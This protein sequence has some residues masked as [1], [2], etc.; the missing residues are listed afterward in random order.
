[1]PRMTAEQITTFLADVGFHPALEFARIETIAER[2]IT[3]RM[4]FRTDFIR[5][6]GTLSGP[7]MMTLADTTAF[8]LILAMQ[9]PL[10][11]AVTSSLAINFLAKPAQ[12]DIVAEGRMLKLGK[13]LAVIAVEM[14]SEG[15]DDLVAHATVT[16]ALPT[17]A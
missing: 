5:P 12:A 3:L 8:F 17:K 1:M 14:R 2:A 16:Y 7:S 15:S 6:G 13:K 11:L 4:P 9:G 10:A